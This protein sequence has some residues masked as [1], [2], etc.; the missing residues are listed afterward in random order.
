M[1]PP[2]DDGSVQP[3][4]E[5]PTIHTRSDTFVVLDKDALTDNDAGKLA[6]HQVQQIRR[7]LRPN[8]IWTVVLY[9]FI[10]SL[11]LIFWNSNEPGHS[12][13]VFGVLLGICTW[14]CLPWLRNIFNLWLDLGDP[15]VSSIEGTVIK[16]QQFRSASRSGQIFYNDYLSIGVSK[17]Q[18]TPA[19]SNLC[20]KE[21]RYRIYYTVNGHQVVNLLAL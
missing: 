2:L 20:E 13:S 19:I 1:Q 18:V 7:Q 17:F 10:I 6:P 11:S 9:V 12:L 8:V 5:R 3:Q 4:P 14:I 15:E 21:G 16:S